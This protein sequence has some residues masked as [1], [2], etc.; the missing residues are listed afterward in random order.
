VP[1]RILG[2]SSGISEDVVRRPGR[3]PGAR[4]D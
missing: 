4:Y 2:L 1:E 3:D